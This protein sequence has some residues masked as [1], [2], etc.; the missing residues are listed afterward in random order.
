[1]TFHGNLRRDE[2]AISYVFT[3]AATSTVKLERELDLF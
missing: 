1:M 2:V 3:T